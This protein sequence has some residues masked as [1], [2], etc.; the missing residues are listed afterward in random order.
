[1]FRFIYTL[2]KQKLGIFQKYLEENL[3]NRFIKKSQLLVK[4]PIFFI[5]KKN[6]ILYLYIYY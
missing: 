6:K 1:M 2:F 5:S 3:K 4:Y